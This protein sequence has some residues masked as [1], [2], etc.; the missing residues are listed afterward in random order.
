MPERVDIGV[1]ASTLSFEA[2]SDPS[3][4][5]NRPLWRLQQ[6][7]R[8]AEASLAARLAHGGDLV[9]ADG[10]LT[11][12]DPTQAPVVGLVK[13]FVRHYLAPPQE[14]LLAALGVGDRTPL[15]ALGEPGGPVERYAW[16]ARLAGFQRHWHDHA[17]VVRCEVSANVGI[18]AALGLAGR[19][20]GMLP[21][22]AGKPTDPR[23]PQNLTVVA[24]LEGWLRH[25]MGAQAMVRRALVAWL[26]GRE[27]T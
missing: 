9:L 25:R 13:R 23:T 2:T 15:F 17:G 19:V 21:A 14:A 6:L 26:A 16:Y 20:S 27:D 7:M 4:D 18:E 3:L 24:G 22:Y 12:S 10:P 5:P 11:F 1:G 8:R